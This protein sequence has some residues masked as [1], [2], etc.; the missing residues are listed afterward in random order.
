[1]STYIIRGGNEG[2]KRLEILARVM[3][4]T[5]AWLL[6][7][8]GIASGMEGLDLGCGGGDVTFELA[9][10][11]GPRGKV[12]GMDRDELKLNL[13]RRTAE[14]TNG[15][16]VQFRNVDVKE[17]GEDSQYDFVY[18]RFL[19]THLRDPLEALRKM[20]RAVRP[21]GIAVVED[22]DFGGS[23]CFP[24]CAAY[25]AYVRL[26]RTMVRHG[27]GDA[28]IGP[29]LY[30]MMVEAEWHDVKLNVVNP[31]FAYGEGKQ[32]AVLTLANIADSLLGE[33]MITQSEL[34]TVTEDL[35][36]FTEDRRTVMSL[37]R[38]FQLWARR[39]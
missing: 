22:I 15:V 21:G 12:V 32:V 16:N 14:L 3:W 5:T 1:M 9:N 30:G 37:P 4:P 18:T 23:F 25:D 6:K 38:V 11:V 36:R 33:K 13:A 2:R 19:L 20:S 7:E 26:Y 10:L 39:K 8:A 24:A 31:T 35:A 28:D 17:W 29:K 34:Q 27:G